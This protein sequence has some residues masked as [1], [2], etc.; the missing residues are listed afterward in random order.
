M[1]KKTVIKEK[2]SLK[3]RLYDVLN[4]PSSKTLMGYFVALWFIVISI[5]SGIVT[6]LETMR[7]LQQYFTIFSIIGIISGFI[8]ILEYFLRI[9]VSNVKAESKR[10]TYMK[11]VFGIIDLIIAISFLLS[12]IFP[13][14]KLLRIFVFLKIIRY[15]QSMEIIWAV[16]KKKRVEFLITLILSALLLFF[17]SILMYFAEYRSQGWNLFNSMWFTAINL[18]T[19]GY[20]DMVPV[21]PQGKFI[22]AVVSILGITL[23]LLPTSVIASGFIDEIKERNP[24]Y[25]ICPNCNKQLEKGKFLKDL[26]QRSRGRPSNAIRKAIEA[27]KS[28]E[29]IKLSSTQRIQ[30]KCYN[31]IEFRFPK[32]IGQIIIFFFFA[33]MITLNVLAIMIST[34]PSLSQEIRPLIIYVLLISII[35]FTIEFLIR[36]WC[37]V[38][39]EREEY[40]DS[41]KGRLKYLSSPLIIADLI[42][43]FSLYITL[44]LFLFSIELQYILMLRLFIVFKIGHFIDVFGVVGN[45]FK[46][47][48]KEFVISILICIIFLILS[49]TVIY[50]VE[51][52]AQPDIFSSI[53]ATIWF[54]VI[55][56]TTT[57]FGD[58]YPVTTLGRFLTIC[59]AFIGVTLFTLPAGILGASFFSSMQEYYLHKICPECG[60]ILSKPKIQ[61]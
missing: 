43:L 45:I 61:K 11:S 15:S 29:P 52:G 21:T 59:L 58:I 55:T 54:G 16:F 17:A 49:C 42:F 36:L 33:T 2:R 30:N 32:T 10:F 23:F 27:E 24:Q 20:G 53:P 50:S 39:S 5:V 4:F 8:F 38:A 1:A 14:V 48:K 25:D 26:N 13:F 22:S 57:G 19:I 9:W 7:D 34:N 56:F 31:L 37:C 3:N 46:D 28:K 41:F 12:F 51:N 18:F 6:M 35:V 44:I 40:E 60:F 47:V